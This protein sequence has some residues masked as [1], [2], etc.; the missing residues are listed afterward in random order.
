MKIKHL[1]E[2]IIR[3]EE[4]DRYV[5]FLNDICIAVLKGSYLYVYKD[6]LVMQIT[7]NT[8][9]KDSKNMIPYVSVV[10][11]GRSEVLALSGG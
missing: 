10:N 3:V 11:V 6:K 8:I 1:S 4:H 5:Y 9:L 7:K 2:V